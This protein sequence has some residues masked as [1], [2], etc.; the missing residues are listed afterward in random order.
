MKL[1]RRTLYRTNTHK[2]YFWTAGTLFFGFLSYD[3]ACFLDV[4]KIKPTGGTY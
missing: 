1:F 2:G 4:R 3:M